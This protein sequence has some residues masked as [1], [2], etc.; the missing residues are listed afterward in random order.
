MELID[1]PASE[2]KVAGKIIRQKVDLPVQ[3]SFRTMLTTP[4]AKGEYLELDLGDQGISERV[5]DTFVQLDD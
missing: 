4:N 5:F 2:G 1:V 3:Q